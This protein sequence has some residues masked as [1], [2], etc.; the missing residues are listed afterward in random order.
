MTTKADTPPSSA[1][2]ASSSPVPM[3][4][5]AAPDAVGEVVGL[6]VEVGEAVTVGEVVIEGEG[7]DV[8]EAVDVGD[9]VDVYPLA[10]RA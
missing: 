5:V 4:P 8:G 6:A 2:W 10:P 7:V 1:G 3:L 9:A